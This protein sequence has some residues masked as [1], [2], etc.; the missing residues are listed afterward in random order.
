MQKGAIYAGL[1]VTQTIAAFATRLCELTGFRLKQSTLIPLARKVKVP[2]LSAQV[3]KDALIDTKDSQAIFDAL[4]TSIRHL[5]WIEDTARRFDG[6]NYF[7][8]KPAE[9]LAWFDQY[10]E[11]K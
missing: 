11:V 8:Q 3:R 2:T 1:D 4:S 7:A 6:Y 10:V 5:V 9:M